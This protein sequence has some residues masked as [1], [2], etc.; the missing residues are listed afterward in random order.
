MFFLETDNAQ[1]KF[2]TGQKPGMIYNWTM[3]VDSGLNFIKKT[4]G[5]LNWFMMVSENFI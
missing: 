3:T 2:F 5:G 1:A 4:H